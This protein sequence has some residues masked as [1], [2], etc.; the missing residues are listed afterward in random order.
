MDIQEKMRLCFNERLSDNK[1]LTNN[2]KKALASLLYSYK[3]CRYSKDGVIIRAM[4][5][6]RKD[7]KMRTNDMYDAVRNLESVYG[8]I[9]R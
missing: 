4:D 1:V 6:L 7:L 2:E 8:M 3:I 9:E 5:T